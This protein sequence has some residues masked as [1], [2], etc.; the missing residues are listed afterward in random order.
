MHDA[1]DQCC[2]CFKRFK[3]LALKLMAVVDLAHAGKGMTQTSLGNVRTNASAAQERAGRSAA[4]MQ[5]PAGDAGCRVK[6]ILALAKNGQGPHA[7][8]AENKI[9]VAE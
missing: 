8:R 1:L 4:V 6:R 2:Q 7:G 3:L 5:R 9:A